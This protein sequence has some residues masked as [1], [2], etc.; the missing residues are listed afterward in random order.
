MT[1]VADPE[2]RHASSPGDLPASSWKAVASKVG[3]RFKEDQVTLLGAG[4]A[5]YGLL[6]LIPSL[7]AAMSI[8]GLVSDPADVARQVENVAGGLPESARNLLTE[9]LDAIVTS[10][11]ANLSIGAIVGIG[12]ALFSASTGI[13]QLIGALNVAYREQESRGFLKLRALSLLLTVGAVVFAAA[14]IAAIAVVPALTR[15]TSVEGAG[16]TAIDWLRWPL[17]LVGFMVALSVLYKVGPDRQDPRWRWVSWGAGIA[18]VIWVLGSVAF[19]VYVTNF[20]SYN[21]TY[22][23]LAGVVVLMLWLL[24]SSIAVLLG[25]FID[26]EL[27]QSTAQDSTTG[28]PEPMGER[29]ATVADTPPEHA[30]SASARS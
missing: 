2:A 16:A 12:L 6:A 30:A 9:Q 20:G 19:S 7:V 4:V 22:G 21:E 13:N 29:G 26:A 3:T 14:A 5:F 11:S 24:I 8:Y 15:G 28:E 10:S 25:A 27:E 23:S 17:L 1:D 18:T